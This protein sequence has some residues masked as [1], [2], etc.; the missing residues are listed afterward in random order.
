[1]WVFFVCHPCLVKFVK[2]WEVGGEPGGVSWDVDDL[3]NFVV[4][5]VS[6]RAGGGRF[7]FKVDAHIGV[8]YFHLELHLVEVRSGVFIFFQP[9]FEGALNF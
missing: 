5:F 9:S 2:F 8:T 1:V 7:I 6:F 3:N 4:L